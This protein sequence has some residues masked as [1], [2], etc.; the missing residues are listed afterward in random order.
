MRLGVGVYVRARVFLTRGVS[1]GTV[2]IGRGRY[3]GRVVGLAAFS[4]V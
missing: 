3:G 2:L 4:F 1:A